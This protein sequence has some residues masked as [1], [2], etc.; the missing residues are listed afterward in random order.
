MDQDSVKTRLKTLN[1]ALET[2]KPLPSEALGKHTKAK[3]YFAAELE[4]TLAAEEAALNALIKSYRADPL[5]T[6]RNR[7]GILKI[8][9]EGVE[10]RVIEKQNE[11]TVD[12]TM[13]EGSVM[14]GSG[15]QLSL[16]GMITEWMGNYPSISII[17]GDKQ[18]RTDDKGALQNPRA[19]RMTFTDP[20]WKEDQVLELGAEICLDHRLQRLRRTVG[21]S[22]SRGASTDNPALDVQLIPSGGMQ[23]LEYSVAAGANGAIF[24]A[25]GCDPILNIY[26][27]AGKNVI[28]GSG[29]APNTVACGVYASMAQTLVSKD[30]FDYYSH[31][32]LAFRSGADQM[33]GF[34]YA[35][36]TSNR[37]GATFATDFPDKI[38]NEHLDAY[39]APQV[40]PVKDSDP[41]ET[42]EYFTAGLGELHL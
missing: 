4:N 25:D 30:G 19:A 11:S 8:G 28:K 33:T 29:T 18:Y 12:L 1:A 34:S 38:G 14:P 37:N 7:A 40:V 23:I 35:E 5:C 16:G 41:S 24:N 20:V 21:M 9:A 22:K 39:A 42:N 32:Q 31:S 36:G 6:V 26:T 2:I 15:L 3:G 13:G 27:N 17:S 10:A